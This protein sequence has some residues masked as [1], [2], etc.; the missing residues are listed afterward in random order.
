MKS[1][2]QFCMF[3]DLSVKEQPPIH[4]ELLLQDAERIF[5]QIL[6]VGFV[7]PFCFWNGVNIGLVG[8]GYSVFLGDMELEEQQPW[9]TSEQAGIYEFA[10]TGGVRGI[11]FAVVAS[12]ILALAYTHSSNVIDHGSRWVK[13][14]HP[15]E[16][17]NDRGYSA[18]I[19]EK[20]ITNRVEFASLGMAG[21]EFLKRLP[22]LVADPG[23]AN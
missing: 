3:S 15:L 23:W 20:S 8:I 22:V 9:I 21:S 19:F 2:I 6:N 7:T 1:I 4:K 18:A 5:S 17:D 14:P 11:S 13:F 12:I 16:L 10:D